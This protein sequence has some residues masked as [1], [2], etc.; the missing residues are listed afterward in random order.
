MDDEGV[1]AVGFSESHGLVDFWY[2]VV[3]GGEVIDVA[4]VAAVGVMGEQVAAEQD[5]ADFQLADF[6]LGQGVFGVGLNFQVGGS[7]L[8]IR[9]GGGFGMGLIGQGAAG[10]GQERFFEKAATIELGGH[11]SSP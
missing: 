7:R 9:R 10:G 2:G 11:S 6:S 4:Q 3:M 1:D 8:R 5:A